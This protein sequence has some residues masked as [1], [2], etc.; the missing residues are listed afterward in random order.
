MSENY[1]S[2]LKLLKIVFD[3]LSFQRR[4]FKN[5]NH[6]NANFN[7][8]IG[9]HQTRSIN[10]VTIIVT[11]TKESEYDLKVRLTGYFEFDETDNISKEELLRK[12]AVAILMPYV[13]TQITMLTSQPE[14]DSLVLPLINV[15]NLMDE[16][17]KKHKES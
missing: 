6:P 16:L 10:M 12:N 8:Q 11:V 7:I 5:D 14:T 1:I 3:E 13:R 4:G 9:E 2:K 15:A 17:V